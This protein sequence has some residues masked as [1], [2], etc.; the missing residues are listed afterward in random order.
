MLLGSIACGSSG[1]GGNTPTA[2]F[3]TGPCP[4]DHAAALAKLSASCGTLTVPEN[5][6]DLTEGNV[7]LPVAI[8]PSATQPAEP[9][10]ILYMAG[11]PGTDAISQAQ[12]LVLVGLNQKREIIIMNQRGNNDTQPKLTCP[13]IDQFYIKAV[14]LPYD[15]PATGTMHVAATKACHDRL[16]AQGLD[17]SAFNTSE[18]TADIADLR[19]AMKIDQ[20]DVYGLSYGTDVALS[21]MRDHPDGIRSVIIDAVVPP[22]A[23]SLGWTWT[24]ANEAVNHIFR[25]CAN[26]PTCASQYGDLSSQFAAQVQLREATPLHINV[27]APFDNTKNV[28]VTLDGGALVNW[29]GSVPDPAVPIPSIPAAIQQLVQGQ[30]TQIAEARAFGADPAAVGIIGYGLFFGVICSVWVPFEPQSQILAQGL[31]AFPNYP[32]SVLSQPA[33][34]PF[35]SEDCQV[36]NVPAAPATVRQLVISTIPTLVMASSFD[37]K[38]SPQ[39]AIN[40]AGTL[41]ASATVVIPGAGHGA[42]FAFG[43]PDDSPARP[44]AKQVVATF[45][46]NP[47]APDTSCVDSLTPPPFSGSPSNLSPAD[48]QEEL[49]NPELF[50]EPY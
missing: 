39:W 45:L 27:P 25:A 6:N 36:W 1:R 4:A 24:N 13:E 44:R 30:P 41:S 26:Q 38:T 49:N 10:P 19:T 35:M 18:S 2:T 28:D 32:Q 8:I 7:Q 17:L 3:K 23:A 14:N 37:G 46:A 5:R 34:L 47:S 9:D 22:S 15:D 48:L 33:L 11:G 43:L 40:V 31:L 42:L 12:I 50:I 20:W 16:M 21:L 29:I